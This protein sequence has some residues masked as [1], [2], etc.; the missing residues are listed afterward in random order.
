MLITRRTL[1]ASSG[2]LVLPRLARAADR[3]T[4]TARNDRD[5]ASL[6]PAF[7]GSPEDGSIIWAV[8][9]RLI[10]FKPGSIE[11]ENDAAAEITQTSDTVVAFRLKPGQ[12]FTDGYGEMTADDVKF[13]FERIAGG[14]PESPYK[15]DWVNLDQVEVTGRYT[16]RIVLK[17]PT[18]YLY[19]IALADGSGCIVSRAAMGKLGS[20]AAFAPVGSGAFRVASLEP[21]RLVRLVPNPGYAGP[22]SPWTEI[23]MRYVPDPQTAGL[24]FRAGELDFTELTP[25]TIGPL[26]SAA[27]TKV[28]QQPG[29]RFVWISLN[30]EKKPLDDPR[31]RQAIQIG[32]DVDQM[33]LAGYNGLAPRANALI[34]PQV[35]GYW[36]DAPV[37]KRDVAAAKALLAAAGV[38]NLTLKLTLLNQPEFQ[39]MGLVAQ[40][41]LRQIGVNL[42]LDVR[43]SGT[44]WSAGEGD[45]GRALDIMLMRFNG[46]LDPNFNTQW[47][48][49]SQ[50]GVWNWSRWRSPA[51]DQLNAQAGMTLDTTRRAEMVVELQK[52]MAASWAFLWLTY[53]V[54]L[55][56][57]RTWLKPAIMP[58]GSDWQLAQFALA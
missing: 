57:S 50:V 30:V 8:F 43:D 9:Q 25:A 33:L 12:M 46:K 58:T 45:A 6:D 22:P 13:S 52:L 29:L 20:R 32:V 7:R 4:Y 3:T 51:F 10:R 36:K 1:V 47:F 26:R 55:F 38:A 49:S 11:W 27:G 34:Q 54:D 17:Q 21:K 40:A 28:T 14:T 18:P 48:T 23:T 2:T 31:V 16:G 37:L 5:V 24:A 53:D 15:S 44:Y 35:L 42:V 39:T 19:T 41:Q 56:A